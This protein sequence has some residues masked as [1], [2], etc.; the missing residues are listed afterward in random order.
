MQTVIFR[1]GTGQGECLLQA[2]AGGEVLWQQTVAKAELAIWLKQAFDSGRLHKDAALFVV[3]AETKMVRRLLTLPPHT[4][5][6]VERA[7]AASALTPVLGE[8][9]AALSVR[10]LGDGRFA[11][12][13]CTKAVL[14][15]ALAPFGRLR[16]RL[17][18]I[19]Q[20]DLCVAAQPALADGYYLE[21]ARLWTAVYWLE[22]GCLADGRASAG[23]GAYELAQ[24]LYE[25]HDGALPPPQTPNLL[26]EPAVP[27]DAA[28]LLPLALTPL[29]KTTDLRRDKPLLALFVLCVLLPGLLWAGLALRPEG[30]SEPASEATSSL[31]SVQRSAYSTL[32]AQAYAAKSERITLSTQEGGEDVLALSGSCAEPLDLADYM[33]RLAAGEPAVQPLLLEMTRQLEN[34][35]YSYTFTV[36]ISLAEEGRS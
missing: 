36:Q 19:T 6:N 9:P 10:A 18:L 31:P 34:D 16:R 33:R 23:I 26:E 14:E 7:M 22:G 5:A 13:G 12:A 1:D 15:A 29:A 28:A 21:Q 30:V 20:A 25:A 8:R 4:H 27:A 3:M 35:R 2:S 17:H 11:L 32:L 24:T